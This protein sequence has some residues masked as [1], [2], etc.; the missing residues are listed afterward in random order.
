MWHL[1]E[2]RAVWERVDVVDIV[3]PVVGIGQCWMSR[4]DLRVDASTVS[5]KPYAVVRQ[6]A[7]SL[8]LVP[9]PPE[10]GPTTEFVRTMLQLGGGRHLRLGSRRLHDWVG[11]LIDTAPTQLLLWVMT[12]VFYLRAFLK[13]VRTFRALTSSQQH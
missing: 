6:V 1:D 7:Y 9:A 12:V 3:A 13:R 4:D 10:S 8:G 2:L 11:Y 5:A